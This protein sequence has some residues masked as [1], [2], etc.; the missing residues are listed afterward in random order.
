MYTRPPA[1]YR[2]AG[3]YRPRRAACQAGRSQ[4]TPGSPLQTQLRPP[5]R[6]CCRTMGQTAS[7]GGHPPHLSH[8]LPPSDDVA[9]DTIDHRRGGSG[10]GV[11]SEG[12]GHRDRSEGSGHRH[13]SEVMD[14]DSDVF[15]A[16]M[17]RCTHG[18]MLRRQV[19]DPTAPQQSHQC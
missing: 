11:R 7:D 8:H 10:Q 12:S 17:W 19:C 16:R 15:G 13:R 5:P 18:Q 14:R 9:P 3:G 1:V 2:R 6:T 4:V